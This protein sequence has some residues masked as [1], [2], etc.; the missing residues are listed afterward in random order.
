MFSVLLVDDEELMLVT[1]RHA[2]SWQK[3][4]FTDIMAV[5]DPYEALRICSSGKLTQRWWI[6]GCRG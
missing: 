3:Y 6:S 5:S 1:M 4:G 2:I